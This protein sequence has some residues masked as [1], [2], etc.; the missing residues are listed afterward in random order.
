MMR[1]S[2]AK[3]DHTLTASAD[4]FLESARSFVVMRSWFT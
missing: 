3:D 4:F 2:N 1:V